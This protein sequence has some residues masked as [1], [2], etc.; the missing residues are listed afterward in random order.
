MMKT[1]LVL[2]A[3]TAVAMAGLS[4]ET[5]KPQFHP[6]IR[7]K[8]IRERAIAQGKWE[9]YQAFKKSVKDAG[10]QPEE[11]FD[12]TIYVAD[13]KLGTPAQSFKI[14]MDTGS[15]NLWVPDKTCS[16]A[17]CDGKN[18]FDSSASTSYVK[19]GRPFFIMY[20]TGSAYGFLGQDVF[21]FGDS[22][23]CFDKQVYGQSTHVAAF[24]KDQPIDGICGL[25]FESI[26]VDHVK[27][28]FLNV[29]DHL[30]NPFFTVWM[31]VEGATEG[32]IGGGITWGGLDTDHCDSNIDWIDLTAKTYYEIKMDSVKVGDTSFKGGS[33]ISDTGTSLIAGPVTEIAKI[34]EALGGKLN[35]SVGL[36]TVPCDKTGLPDVVF[37][38]N[39]KDYAI[40]QKNYVIPL[41]DT[42]TVCALGFQGFTSPDPRWILGDCFI[43]Q[44]CNTYD[45]K[46][47]RLGLSLAT[48]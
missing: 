26:A 18:N 15:S 43:R 23:L 35:A 9:E 10:Y 34:C 48:K 12:D 17:G 11:D 5:R 4:P 41:D 1:S 28:P 32:K 38:I 3:L 19:D 44:Y 29:M 42:N 8:S 39:G 7:I 14:V 40:K 21:C 6:L 46:N 16:S 37:T 22:G 25:A 13:I 45:P 27:P 30:D 36:Y 24:F 33:A 2:L 31:T 47:G 20:G